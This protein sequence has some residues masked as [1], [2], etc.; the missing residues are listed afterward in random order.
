MTV[1]TVTAENLR[2]FERFAPA[3][4]LTDH[5]LEGRH[6][7][8]ALTG[9]QGSFVPA[10]LMI[11]G[12]AYTGYE[13]SIKTAPSVIIHWLYVG[14]TERRKGAGSALMDGLLSSL[15]NVS[16]NEIRCSVEDPVED[17]GLKQF[18]ENM[19]FVFDY[20]ER[21][22]LVRTLGEFDEKRKRIQ[23]K[24][25]TSVK[26]LSELK[27]EELKSI[28][29]IF[30]E[31]PEIFDPDGRLDCEPELSY[32]L[33]HKNQISGVYLVAAR[34][35]RP[36]KHALKFFF[37]RILPGIPVTKTQELLQV[38]FVKA[39]ESYGLEVPVYIETEYPPSVALIK[40]LISDCPVEKV[41]TGVRKLHSGK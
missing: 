19:G 12:I 14:E 38:S 10:G 39:L 7:I 24:G 28:R 13:K 41:L 21:I 40:Y 30:G 15:K 4:T 27:R 9:E 23:F 18:L 6:A 17:N 5:M 25:E 32:V 33:F 35:T 22:R 2:A 37:M 34:H 8:G 3:G 31:A 11:F 36:D 20:T 16:I 1:T 29:E 26:P